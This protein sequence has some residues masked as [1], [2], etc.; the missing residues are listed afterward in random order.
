MY[1]ITVSTITLK[2]YEIPHG[3]LKFNKQFNW[4]AALYGEI[5]CNC[6]DVIAVALKKKPII[7]VFYI[8]SPND[9]IEA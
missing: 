8:Y 7:R 4:P 6:L 3:N 5:K 1:N 9:F 2:Y